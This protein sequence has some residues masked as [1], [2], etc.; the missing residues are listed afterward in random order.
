MRSVKHWRQDCREVL[1]RPAQSRPHEG[2]TPADDAAAGE[3]IPGPTRRDPDRLSPRT[4][5]SAGADSPVPGPAGGA[6]F[7]ALRQACRAEDGALN[8][9]VDARAAQPVIRV[10]LDDC[11]L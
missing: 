6:G 2:S 11:D 1:T 3:P 10:S 8:A 5:L 4:R 9:L 7:P